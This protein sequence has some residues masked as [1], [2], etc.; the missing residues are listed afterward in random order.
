MNVRV[1]GAR[2]IV[3]RDE[4]ETQTMSGIIL[5]ESSVE[6]NYTG[7][8]V[9]T[10]KGARLENGN[11]MPME[12]QVGDRVLFTRMAGVP[13]EVEGEEGEFLVINERD[14]LAIFD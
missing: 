13:I 2:L 4:K 11:L 3:K 7:V 8:V 1:F 9:A 12:V 10:G 14:V 5:S 6:E